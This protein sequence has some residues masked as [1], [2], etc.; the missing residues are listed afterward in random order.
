VLDILEKQEDGSLKYPKDV[1]IAFDKFKASCAAIVVP[2]SS[3]NTPVV[4]ST[5]TYPLIG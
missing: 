3:I 4:V 1:S 2:K 5:T